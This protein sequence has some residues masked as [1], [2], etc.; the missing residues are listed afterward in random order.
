MQITSTAM[1]ALVALTVSGLALAQDG[2]MKAKPPKA[3]VAP[4]SATKAGVAAQGYDV[5]S[6]FTAGQ[7]AQGKPEFTHT[8]QGATFQFS[9]AANRDAFAREPAKYAPQYGGYCA[10]AVSHG[11]TAPSDPAAFKIVDGK[12]YLNYNKDV[13]KKW[14]AEQGDLIGKANAN[15]PGLHK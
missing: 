7:P 2:A 10:W 13:Q 3:P 8:Y 6:Y 14:E 12:L 9:S 5:V 1:M 4:V 11:Y 15:W